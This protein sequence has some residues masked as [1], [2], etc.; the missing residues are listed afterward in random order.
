MAEEKKKKNRRPT[1]AKREIQHE[2]R[3]KENKEFKSKVRTAIRRLEEALSGQEKEQTQEALNKVYA[4]MDK[5]VKRGVYK[6]NK[7]GRTKSRLTARAYAH[8]AG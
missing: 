7:A 6:L 4:L 3:R 8:L 1:A 5:G 2:K